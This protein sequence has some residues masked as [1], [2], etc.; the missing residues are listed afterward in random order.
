MSNS[1]SLE[2]VAGKSRIFLVDAHPV[3]RLGLSQLINEQS[4]LLVCGETGD[5]SHVITSITELPPDLILLDISA[6]EAGGMDLLRSIKLSRPELPCLI[7]TIFPENL[8]GPLT[9]ESG[10]SGYL[11]KK[12]PPA[13]IL[14]AIRE[15]LQGKTYI[16][17]SLAQQMIEELVGKKTSQ[18][19]G[20]KQLSERELEVFRLIGEWKSTSQ[21]ARELHLSIKT[22]EYYR[23]QIKRKLQLKTAPNLMRYATD[24]VRKTQEAES[25]HYPG[26]LEN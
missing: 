18:T 9:L 24:W 6:G 23:E 3:F 14:A 2:P 26:S 1:H 15:V 12:S 10:A 7:L 11:L 13:T 21:I 22:I 16:S 19:S 4:D 8:Y 17:E 5:P 20:V 25:G